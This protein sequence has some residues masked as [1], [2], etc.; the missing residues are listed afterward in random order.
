MNKKPRLIATD[1]DGT[2]VRND[3]ITMSERTRAAL[4]RA[5]DAGIYV[6]PVTGRSLDVLP[7]GILPAY[8]HIITSNGASV[9]D[10]KAKATILTR[11]LSCEE[12]RIAWSIL[13][14]TTDLVE[15]FVRNKMGIDRCHF[16]NIH[17]IKVPGHHYEYYTKG[18]PLVIDSYDEFIKND[19]SGIEKFYMPASTCE[20]TERAR[21]ELRKTGIFD[22]SSSGDNNLELNKRGVDKGVALRGLC[23]LLGID[24]CDVVAFGDEA[25]D[26]SMLSIAGYGVAMGNASEKVLETAKYRTC[27]NEEDGLAVFLEE[28][29]GI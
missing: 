16:E 5:A 7:G 6:V 14:Q 10:A 11:H 9:Y 2:A 25:N 19:A 1:M 15:I 28:T 4:T 8:S 17:N 21:E 20:A 23:E 13:S 27:T 22:V 18:S 29:F 24:L 3:H 26:L 12:A